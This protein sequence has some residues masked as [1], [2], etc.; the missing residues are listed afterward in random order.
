M[1]KITVDELLKLSKEEIIGKIIVFPTDTVY[2]VGA[3]YTDKE[4]IKKIYNLK[5]R[6]KS[7]PLACLAPNQQAILPYIK[8]N[9]KQTFRLMNYWPGALTLIFE[10][11]HNNIDDKDFSTIGFRIPN[12]KVALKILNYLG[13]MA[14]TS[15][16]ISGQEPLNDLKTI[17]ENFADEI[18]YLVID[19]EVL[20]SVSSTVIDISEETMKVL[21]KGDILEKINV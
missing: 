16:N 1:I 18:D 3:I 15:M 2:G 7:K 17:E 14:V 8:I 11:K 5:H 21:R 10:K 9:N 4:A 12:S 6:D 19:E 20:S 13:I